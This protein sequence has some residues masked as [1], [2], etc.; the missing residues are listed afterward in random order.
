M[1]RGRRGGLDTVVIL[2]YYQYM[3]VERLAVSFE[4]ELAKEVRDAASLTLDGNVSAWL[5]EAARNKLRQQALGEAVR[6]YE[7]EEGEFSDEEM[8]E[9]GAEWPG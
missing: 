3:S 9:I 6:Q 7:A 4:P 5:A 2:E 1:L 8:A